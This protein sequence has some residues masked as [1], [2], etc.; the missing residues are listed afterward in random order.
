MMTSGI[1]SLGSQAVLELG[2]QIA[3][4]DTFSEDNDPYVSDVSAY[5]SK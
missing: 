4:Y 1:R 2:N 5:G 3:A